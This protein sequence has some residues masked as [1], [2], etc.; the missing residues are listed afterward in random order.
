M[1]KNFETT[2]NSAAR[3]WTPP[4]PPLQKAEKPELR[5]LLW[6]IAGSILL[7]DC[8]LT[9]GLNLGFSV[10][11]IWVLTCSTGYLISCGCRP[12]WYSGSL[13]VMALVILTGFAR[14]ADGFVKYVML[15]FL[16]LAA[17]LGLCLLAGKNRYPAAGV[18]SLLDAPGTLFKLG[19]GNM[20]AAGRGIREAGKHAGT[21]GKRRTSVLLG[22]VLAVP[23]TAVTASLLMRADAAFEGL[24]AALPEIQWQE[25][26]SAGILGVAGAWILYARNVSLRRSDSPE[27]KKQRFRGIPL[28][29]V[30]T[31]LVCMCLVYVLY[32]VSQLAYLSGGFSGILPAGY[33]MAEYA[34]RGFFEMA[35]L[36]ALNLGVIACCVGLSVQEGGGRRLCRWLCLF[37]GLMTCFLV[38]AASGKMGMYIR[39]YGLTRLRVLTEVVMLFLGLATVVVCLWLFLPNIPYM[40]VILLAALVLGAGVFWADVDTQVARYN[41]RAYLAGELETVD[42]VYLDDLG[43]GALPYLAELA[44]TGNEDAVQA[45]AERNVYAPDDIRG[46]NLAV[47]QGLA[48]LEEDGQPESAETFP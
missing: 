41:V 28:L 7:W 25:L 4:T 31:V 40:K 24:T 38:A 21:S 13:L 44:K 33:T 18:R 6:L 34:R 27:E 8:I 9:G 15:H 23:V 1:E 20:G 35:W 26:V 29:T 5:L 45:I 48:A 39:S 11:G 43:P 22:L 3:G 47:S 46:W 16:L 32:L 30:N 14:S 36:C 37:L 17:N 19:F 2:P 10:A 12:D 42:V